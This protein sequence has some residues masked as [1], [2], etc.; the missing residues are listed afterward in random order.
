MTQPENE[1]VSFKND[2][3]EVFSFFNQLMGKTTEVY[4][5]PQTNALKVI[6]F[7]LIFLFKKTH[8]F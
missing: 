6:P 7:F 8:I 2:L 3:L 5:G 4:R 1:D